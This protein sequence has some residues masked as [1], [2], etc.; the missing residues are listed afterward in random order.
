M[1][2]LSICYISK[3]ILGLIKNWL[4]PNL[5]ELTWSR[6][7]CLCLAFKVLQILA[8]PVFLFCLSPR[9]LSMFTSQA[10]RTWCSSHLEYPSLSHLIWFTSAFPLAVTTSMFFLGNS[11]LFFLSRTNPAIIHLVSPP[12]HLSRIWFP[13]CLYD[14]LTDVCLPLCELREDRGLCSGYTDV[15]CIAVHSSVSRC[16]WNIQ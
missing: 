16:S 13:T 1:S 15:H 2:P 10:L 8:Q 9:G 3:K 12:R 14:Y 6:K 5:K 11:S 7:E 4:R